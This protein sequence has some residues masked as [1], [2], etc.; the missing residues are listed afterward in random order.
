M[1]MERA[2]FAMGAVL[3]DF[4]NFYRHLILTHDT[5][6]RSKIKI[7]CFDLLPALFI[8]EFY[9]LLTVHPDMN[10]VNN[11]LD[12]QCFMYVYSILYMFRAAMC[13]S[14]GE[15]LYQCDTWCMSLCVDDRLV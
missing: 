10:H 3:R 13:P 1:Q 2:V 11:Q 4:E 9:V 6:L 12:A 5:C 8:A 7:F 15:L 14:P